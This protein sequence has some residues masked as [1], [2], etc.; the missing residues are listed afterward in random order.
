[1]A[2]T[3]LWDAYYQIPISCSRATADVSIAAKIIPPLIKEDPG[4][5]SDAMISAVTSDA[6]E[7]QRRGCG[8]TG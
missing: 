6:Q 1:M 3:S 2:F 7:L 8:G 4:A 5:V